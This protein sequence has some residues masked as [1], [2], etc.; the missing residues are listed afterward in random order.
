MTRKRLVISSILLH[1][2]FQMTLTFI[3][4]LHWFL[5]VIC[6]IGYAILLFKEYNNKTQ[7]DLLCN[8]YL[9]S[10]IFTIIHFIFVLAYNKILPWEIGLAVLF[11]ILILHYSR[12]LASSIFKFDISWS[13]SIGLRIFDDFLPW[14]CVGCQ[15]D[16]QMVLILLHRRLLW[17][18]SSSLVFYYSLTH[19]NS[20]SPQCVHQPSISIGFLWWTI[21]VTRTR[22]CC[23]C[24]HLCS[25]ASSPMFDRFSLWFQLIVQATHSL[26]LYSSRCRGHYC[27]S[28]TWFSTDGNL[29]WIEIRFQLRF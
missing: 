12:R 22:I 19:A 9:A 27:Q 17:L 28:C 29:N 10:L 26:V 8:H 7:P 5:L 18:N 1:L 23:K 13:V 20:V 2:I 21:V 14:T 6:L 16:I 15:L 25:F 4:C 11:I 24:S 3:S